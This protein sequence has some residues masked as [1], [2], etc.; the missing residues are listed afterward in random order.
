MTKKGKKPQKIR[1]KIELH[2]VRLFFY[3]TLLYLNF[4]C[5]INPEKVYGTYVPASYKITK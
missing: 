2:S 1:S 4:S 3:L 5:Q